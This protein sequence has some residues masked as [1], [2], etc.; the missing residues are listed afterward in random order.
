MNTRRTLNKFSI[1]FNLQISL[2][3]R[4]GYVPDKS[5]TVNTKTNILRLIRLIQTENISFLL[6]FAVFE[7]VNSQNRDYQGRE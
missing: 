5:Q 7:S 2:A 4:G 1:W 3:I 6:L